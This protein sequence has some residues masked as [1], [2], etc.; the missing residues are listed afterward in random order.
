MNTAQV[1]PIQD[2]ER[3]TP[4]SP[5]ANVTMEEGLGISMTLR[6]VKGITAFCYG[7]VCAPSC[8]SNGTVGALDI[9]SFALYSNDD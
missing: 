2:E 1:D 7:N 4:T 5:C 6:L 9:G 3:A 8:T